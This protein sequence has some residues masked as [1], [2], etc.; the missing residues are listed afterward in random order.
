MLLVTHKDQEVSR[1]A[2]SNLLS[3]KEND[4]MKNSKWMEVAKDTVKTAVKD[5]L[6]VILAAATITEGGRFAEGEGDC[7]RK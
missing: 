4:N 6:S 1:T 3:L 7:W 5:S 2:A